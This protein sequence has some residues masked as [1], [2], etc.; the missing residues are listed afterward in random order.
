MMPM[1]RKKESDFMGMFEYRRDQEQQILRSLVYG[2]QSL[3]KRDTSAKIH[4]KFSPLQQG[5]HIQSPSDYQTDPVF[6]SPKIVLNSN[7]AE[8]CNN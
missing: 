2:K 7:G 6:G 5:I 4:V 3:R 8:F 1:I